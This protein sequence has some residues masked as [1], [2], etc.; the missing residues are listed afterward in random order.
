MTRKHRLAHRLIWIALGAAVTL[1]ITMSL[2]LR[3]PPDPPAKAA[4]ATT[5][6][7]QS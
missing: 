3:P 7:L 4:G 1:G 6:A 2:V 5:G